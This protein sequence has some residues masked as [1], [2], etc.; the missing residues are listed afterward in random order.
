[1]QTN[2]SALKSSALAN[3]TIDKIMVTIGTTALVWI[4]AFLL[5]AMIVK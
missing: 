3:K 4:L 5:V 2:I 1:M